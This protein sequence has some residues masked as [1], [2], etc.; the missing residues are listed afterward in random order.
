[1]IRAAVAAIALTTAVV[2]WVETGR[3][4]RYVGIYRPA[5]TFRAGDERAPLQP[6]RRPPFIRTAGNWRVPA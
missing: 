6:D 3:L 5:Y 1:M 4:S 2:C